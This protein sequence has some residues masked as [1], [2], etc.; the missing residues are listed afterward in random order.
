MEH[1]FYMVSIVF[2]KFQGPQDFKFF[3]CVSKVTSGLDWFS[4]TGKGCLTIKKFV[5]MPYVYSVS[6]PQ[7]LCGFRRVSIDEEG[8]KVIQILNDTM[9]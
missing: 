1:D 6:I 3:L 5:K 8:S 7:E 9:I 4:K 2:K